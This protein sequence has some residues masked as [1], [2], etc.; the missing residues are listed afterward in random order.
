MVTVVHE[1]LTGNRETRPWVSLAR[2]DQIWQGKRGAEGVPVGEVAGGAGEAAEE[3][4]ELAEGGVAGDVGGGRVALRELR[5]VAVED[6]A[7]VPA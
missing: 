2:F 7:L 5:L 4:L 6:R 3:L 1:A